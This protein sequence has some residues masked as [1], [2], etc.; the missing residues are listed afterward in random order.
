MDD[1]GIRVLQLHTPVQ[2]RAEL[3]EVG[4]DSSLAELGARAEFQ[5]VKIERV[6]LPLARFLYQE[7]VIEGG[8]VVTAPRLEH[9][10][11]GTTDVLL[12][13]TRYQLNHLL[14]RLRWQPSAE[15]EWLADRLERVLDAFVSPPRMG[16]GRRAF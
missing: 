15:L 9:T 14:V 3:D 10:G 12:C 7:L 6:S 8:Q 11:Q 4:A 2:I 1:A 13:A 16:F 5:I